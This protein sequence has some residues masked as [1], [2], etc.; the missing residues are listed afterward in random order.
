VIVSPL[1]RATFSRLGVPQNALHQDYLIKPLLGLSALQ[2]ACKT[3]DTDPT[4]V[5]TSAAL[6]Y[7][8]RA[9]AALR[10]ALN[11]LSAKHCDAILVSTIFIVVCSMVAAM[12]PTT[13]DNVK[14]TAE[15]I[16]PMAGK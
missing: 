7:Q 16:R 1:A 13:C 3:V 14:T 5:Y 15:T 12:L 6:Q 10:I 4:G 8:D 9:A 2:I 11:D